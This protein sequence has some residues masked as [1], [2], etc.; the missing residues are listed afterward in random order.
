MQLANAAAQQ[1]E[2]VLIVEQRKLE[3]RIV[4]Q[5]EAVRV[6]GVGL[7]TAGEELCRRAFRVKIG[8]KNVAGSTDQLGSAIARVGDGEN[9]VG[10][11][12]PGVD[13]VRDAPRQ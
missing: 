3:S 4:Q 5:R 8:V 12:C 1:N 9:L 11:R 2:Q 13:E 6:E 10:L 7:Q